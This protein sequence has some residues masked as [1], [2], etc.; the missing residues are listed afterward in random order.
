MPCPEEHATGG[1]E[2]SCAE[3]SPASSAGAGPSGG[4]DRWP[5]GV[6]AR[7]CLRACQGR[8]GKARESHLP[9]V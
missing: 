9:Q 1:P 8:E 2:G 3:G 5:L 6:G 7:A 4:I